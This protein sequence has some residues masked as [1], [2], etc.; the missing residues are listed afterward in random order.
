MPYNPPTLAQCI[1]KSRQDF[2]ANLPGSNA[3]L[4]PNN[5][6]VSAKVM[7]GLV[8][9]AFRFLA[10]IAKQILVSTCSREYLYL[11]GAELGVTPKVATPSAGP[12]QVYGTVTLLI[13]Q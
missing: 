9:S 7:G 12:I 5:I 13:P 3:W 6:A 8:W 10:W 2:Q 11:H 4:F 1:E